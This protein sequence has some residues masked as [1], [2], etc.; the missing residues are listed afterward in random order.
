MDLLDPQNINV[1]SNS[2][3]FQLKVDRKGRK[4]GRCKNPVSDL[5]DVIR[6][7]RKRRNAMATT[8]S[9]FVQQ[10]S[11]SSLSGTTHA[12]YQWMTDANGNWYSLEYVQDTAKAGVQDEWNARVETFK[13]EFQDNDM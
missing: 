10:T 2:K 13:T 6:R 4:N 7:I 3:P 8:T 1:P 5:R 11:S 12:N 9:S